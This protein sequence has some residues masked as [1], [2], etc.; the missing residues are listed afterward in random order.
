MKQPALITER[1]TLRCFS[2]DDAEAIRLL[3]GNPNVS[4]ST[5]NIPHPYEAGMAEQWIST[6]QKSWAQKTE[7]TYAITMTQTGRLVGAINLHEITEAKAELGYWIGE[8]YWGNGYCTEAARA[9]INFAFEQ[10]DLK[11]IEAEHLTTNPGSGRVMQKLGMR[12]TG[13]HSK[14]DRYGNDSRME[15]YEILNTG[16]DD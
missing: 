6:H 14:K 8:P 1:L 13:H 4:N 9:L 15:A 12:H 7:L 5:L 3:A 16:A 2:V 11:K 10:F